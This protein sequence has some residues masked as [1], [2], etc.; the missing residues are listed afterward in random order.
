MGLRIDLI[1]FISDNTTIMWSFGRTLLVKNDPAEINSFIQSADSDFLLFW[2]SAI[3]LPSESLIREI[4][5]TTGDVWQSGLRWGVQ[6]KPHYLNYIY[7]AWMYNCDGD[8]EITTTSWRLTFNGSILKTDILK[9]S[10]ALDLRYKD[11]GYMALDLGYRLI[12]S[13]AI[14]RYDPRL[15]VNE[16]NYTL[17]ISLQ[18]EWLFIC[19]YF[20]SRW[21]KWVLYRAIINTGHLAENLKWYSKYSALSKYSFRYLQHKENGFDH[22]LD[23]YRNNISVLAPTLNRYSYLEAELEQ[24]AAQSLM[25]LEVLVT[26][27]TPVAQRQVIDTGKYPDLKIRVFPQNE[28]GQC[29]AWN[30]LLNEA[31]GDYVFFLGDDADDID[32]D[33]LERMSMSMER[34]KVDMIA[35]NVIE[36][37]NKNTIDEDFTRISD[38]FPITLIKKNT[39]MNA[40]GMDMLFNKGIRADGDL[41]MRCYLNG[42]VFLFDSSLRIF[43]HRASIGGLRTHKER[44]VTRNMSKTMITK[45]TPPTVTEKIIMKRYFKPFQI[46]EEMAMRK[47][48]QLTMEGNS[49]KKMLKLFS[50][51]IWLFKNNEKYKIG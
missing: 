24:L 35:T 27:Q 47:M 7:P 20:S 5:A 13:G 43:H 33:F 45:F 15:I 18:D 46:K 38:T 8:S 30:K 49:L 1:C 16:S 29:I 34:F 4:T 50:G 23:K 9:Q 44:A 14:I 17:S 26:D 6:S 28:T 19:K 40:G 31:R 11:M 39:V 25:P 51:M 37:G 41:A 32:P 12:R 42:A 2:N 48:S 36:A 10:E 22:N 3:P 21:R